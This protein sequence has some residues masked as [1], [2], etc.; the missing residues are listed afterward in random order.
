MPPHTCVAN[1]A[2]DIRL[3]TAPIA[4]LD[5]LDILSHLKNLNTELMARDA[6]IREVWKFAEVTSDV[7]SANPD[8]MNAYQRLIVLGARWFGDI[9]LVPEFRFSEL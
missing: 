1:T 4:Y 3:Y 6:W 9:D 7:R 5:V 8:P 2:V